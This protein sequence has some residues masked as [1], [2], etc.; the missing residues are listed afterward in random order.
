M[1]DETNKIRGWKSIGAAL[2]VSDDTAQKY[3]E[4]GAFKAHKDLLPVFRD[5]LGPWVDR[6]ALEQWK[7]RTT[8][9]WA[10]WK[11]LKKTG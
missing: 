8:L 7:R 3:A 6:D 11:S 4:E 5:Y 1:S 9:A 2:G 10:A